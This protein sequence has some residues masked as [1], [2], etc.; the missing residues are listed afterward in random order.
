MTIHYKNI[1]TLLTEGFRAEELR[2]FCLYEPG[3][4]PVYNQLAQNTGKTSI[5][6]LLIEHADN[7][8]LFNPLL[9]WA[10]EQ[11]PNKYKKYQPYGL[12]PFVTSSSDNPKEFKKPDPAPQKSTTLPLVFVSYSHRDEEEKEMVVSHLNLLKRAKLIDLWVDDRIE[13]GADWQADIEA[14]IAKA[15]IAILLI[16][17]NFLNS[18]FILGE[19]IPAFLERRESE[20]LIVFPVIA[21]ACKWDIFEWLA[22][23]NVR[24]KNARPIWS[25]T[26][27]QIEADL[28][29]IAA[30]VAEI[31][32]KK[33]P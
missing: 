26:K 29:K 20:G 21:R 10:K 4:K 32:K 25:G 31:A 2:S 22:K 17:A 27:S 11:S 7:K 33:R 15:N 13:G 19:E 3:F 16:S 5:I 8:E 1:R 14:A 18:D 6:D 24:P 23:M 9:G 30:E 12:T 28:A